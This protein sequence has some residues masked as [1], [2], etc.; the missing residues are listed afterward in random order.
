M[1]FK[2]FCFFPLPKILLNIVG[3]RI[4]FKRRACRHFLKFFK[5]H[6]PSC[7]KLFNSSLEIFQFYLQIVSENPLEGIVNTFA[8]VVFTKNSP[9]FGEIFGIYFLPPFPVFASIIQ[10]KYRSCHYLFQIFVVAK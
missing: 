3:I 8:F 9:S 4:F 2:S 6:F 1:F 10:N 5:S 7:L